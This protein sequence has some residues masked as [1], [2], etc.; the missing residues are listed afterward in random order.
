MV[1]VPQKEEKGCAF[2]FLCAGHFELDAITLFHTSLPSPDNSFIK[3]GARYEANSM[4]PFY[5]RDFPCPLLILESVFFKFH[6]PF[7]C[8][9]VTCY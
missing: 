6:F 1:V 2:Y 5:R 4:D 3:I 9:A 7:T 8:Q